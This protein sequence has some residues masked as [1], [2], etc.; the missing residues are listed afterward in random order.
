MKMKV[1]QR[2]QTQITVPTV[3]KAGRA[4]LSSTQQQLPGQHVLIC[5]LAQRGPCLTS[6]CTVPCPLWWHKSICREKRLLSQGK[7]LKDTNLQET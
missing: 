4:E 3:G 5:P 7:G 6:A 1:R 2:R